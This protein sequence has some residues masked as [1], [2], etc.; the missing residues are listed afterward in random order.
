MARQ[1][2]VKL[3]QVPVPALP[4]LEAPSRRMLAVL[5]AIGG[6]LLFGYALARE[7]SVFAVRTVQVSGAPP[8]VAAE[9]RGALRDVL[10]DSLVALD[11]EDIEARVL[12]LPSVR[13][14]YVDRSFPHGLLVAVEPERPLA[15]L[16]A[17]SEAWVVSAD[18][19]VL[20]AVES[21]AASRLPR[22]RL[23][24]GTSLQRGERLGD[25]ELRL[26]LGLLRAL[27]RDF[28]VR[29]LSA[30][31]TGGE[32]SLV[33]EDWIKVRLG[34]PDRLGAKLAAAGAVLRSLPPEERSAL[35]Y[36][37]ASVPERVAAGA[38]TQPES[39]G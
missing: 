3:P 18:S 31:A 38:K 35:G 1:P 32:V 17:G 27:P 12:E 16:T 23:P 7:T 34:P 26:A 9:I 37:D 28:P 14:A 11:P 21:R 22:I 8:E 5:A 29:V 24:G 25:P 6:A 15:L 10:G 4:R 30:E 19:R 36:L 33:V 39:E 20:R 13:L 2:A